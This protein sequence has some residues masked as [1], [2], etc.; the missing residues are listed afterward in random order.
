MS[1]P[2]TSEA[3]RAPH[4][5]GPDCSDIDRAGPAQDDTRGQVDA[6]A[7]D[8]PSAGDPGREALST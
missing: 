5:E 6:S 4:A 7:T 2:G 8:S 3:P 1:P